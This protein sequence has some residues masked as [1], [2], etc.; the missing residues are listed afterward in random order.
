VSAADGRVRAVAGALHQR[1]EVADG[2]A[3]R[4][5]RGDLFGDASRRDD[6][7]DLLARLDETESLPL[8]CPV[9]T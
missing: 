2:V 4:R 5:Q 6:V 1:L 3:H 7:A 9:V 8:S